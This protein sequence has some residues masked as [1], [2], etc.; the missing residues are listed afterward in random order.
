M[1]ISIGADRILEF[2][3]WSML[4]FNVLG[5]GF[6][7]RLATGVCN[8]STEAFKD[9]CRSTTTAGDGTGL[10]TMVGDVDGFLLAFS[11]DIIRFLTDI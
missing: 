6:E 1:V 5:S 11:R 9:C 2:T 10:V 7:K 3:A 4:L 8:G